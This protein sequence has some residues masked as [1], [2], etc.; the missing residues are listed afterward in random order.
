MS[1]D[2]DA[3]AQ[4]LEKLKNKLESLEAS[5]GRQNTVKG[6]GLATIVVLFSYI[7][8]SLYSI[9]SNFESQKF[10]DNLKVGLEEN[11][12]PRF[13][14]LIAK[15][16]ADLV[17]QVREAIAKSV[18]SR[19][20]KFEER[21]RKIAAKVTNTMHTSLESSLADMVVDIEEAVLKELG[22]ERFAIIF[23][24]DQFEEIL[25]EELVAQLDSAENIAQRFREELEVIKERNPKYMKMP[26]K[27]LRK[28]WLFLFWIS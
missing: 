11:F 28:S 23:E 7:V 20:P 16:Q 27:Q 9:Y 24:N 15:S 6:I 12:Q 25:A 21:F 19:L 22:D 5:R 3:K 2:N 13:E 10:A 4:D 1:D 8:F 26:Q 18:E 17:P 14:E